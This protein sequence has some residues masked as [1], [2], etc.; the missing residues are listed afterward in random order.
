MSAVTLQPRDVI[1]TFTDSCN[2][3]VS[4]W[5]CKRTYKKD[6]D[7]YVNSR[8]ELEG[9]NK[10]KAKKNIEESFERAKTNLLNTLKTR[11]RLI[12]GNRLEFHEKAGN[13][14]T[15]MEILGKINIAHIDGI[16]ELMLE[17]LKVKIEKER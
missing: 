9:F 7:V 4:C 1:F 2:C 13:I 15:S 17:Y 12:G 5:C 6:R 14:L 10:S 16:N 3:C 11:L 8:G